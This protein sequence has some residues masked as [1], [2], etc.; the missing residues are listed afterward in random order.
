[1]NPKILYSLQLRSTHFVGREHDAYV[2]MWR[3]CN[4]LHE[5]LWRF[6]IKCL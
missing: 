3:I 1:M 2:P 4:I 5:K 6:R